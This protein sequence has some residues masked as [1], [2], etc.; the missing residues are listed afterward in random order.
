MPVGICAKPWR[1]HCYFSEI[2]T[3]QPSDNLPRHLLRGIIESGNQELEGTLIKVEICLGSRDKVY[4]SC[5][6]S[7]H[8]RAQFDTRKNYRYT[9]IFPGVGMSFLLL[10]L[11]LSDP[12]I[13]EIPFLPLIQFASAMGITEG[14]PVRINPRSF[15]EATGKQA[16]FCLR[17]SVD[18]RMQALGTSCPQ[19]VPEPIPTCPDDLSAESSCN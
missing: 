12:S 4:R 8:T 19:Q 10:Y 15:V 9:R 16:P 7:R 1:F 6:V 3:S 17:I 13:S 14:D 5:Q 2:D 18:A 11:N